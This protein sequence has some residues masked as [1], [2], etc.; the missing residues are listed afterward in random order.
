MQEQHQEDH[1]VKYTDF[2]PEKNF[3]MGFG[4]PRE[5]VDNDAINFP[6]DVYKPLLKALT[7]IQQ[8]K[9]KYIRE[10]AFTIWVGD[11]NM[12]FWVAVPDRLSLK[13]TNIMRTCFLNKFC[14][15]FGETEHTSLVPQFRYQYGYI[16]EYGDDS[17][18]GQT[19]I[20]DE[21]W[22]GS[23]ATIY[24]R[25]PEPSWLLGEERYCSIPSDC[26]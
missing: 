4:F 1:Y 17:T 3:I 11:F 6:G 18:V 2:I 25:L 19:R 24:Y 8:S 20:D 7:M 10:R 13:V 23:G 21:D 14:V 5:M 16:I 22:Y 26:D 15:S 12:R 9:N